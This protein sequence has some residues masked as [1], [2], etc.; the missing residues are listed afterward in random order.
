MGHVEIE[1]EKRFEPDYDT[2]ARPFIRENQ[3][4]RCCRWMGH[5][6]LLQENEEPRFPVATGDDSFVAF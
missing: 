6:N 1:I 5:R 2:A 4:N 3:L